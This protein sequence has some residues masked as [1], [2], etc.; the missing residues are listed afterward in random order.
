[1][2]YTGVIRYGARSV[3]SPLDALSQP[4]PRLQALSVRNDKERCRMTLASLGSELAT[5]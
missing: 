5:L 3:R 1:M 2:I 4:V